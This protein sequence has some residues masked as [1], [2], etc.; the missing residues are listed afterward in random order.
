M[1]AVILA[2]G[3]GTRLRPYSHI[4]PKPLMP[5]EKTPDGALKT[6]LEKLIEQ[7]LRARIDDIIIAVNYKAD[8][9]CEFIQ[10]GEW[11]GAKV[12]Y[13]Y[14]GTLDGNA[15]AFYRAQQLLGHADVLITDCDNYF[16]DNDIFSDLRER[17]EAGDAMLTVGVCPVDDVRKFAII[18]TDE[19]GRPVDI[20]EKPADPA[21]WGH[22]AKSGMM[23]LKSSL[24]KLDRGIA[25]TE[26]GEYTTTR[27]I[28]TCLDEG[29]LVDLFPIEDGFRDIGTWAEYLPLL[30]SNL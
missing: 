8:L 15:G 28:K 24:A 17:H 11:L 19:A 22:L 30:K 4:L 23:I 3:R 7:L 9:I 26:D 27:I 10:D 16:T 1:K 12:S 2:A 29:S 6:I 20:Y 25:E 21:E 14:Q 13:V 18:K 5:I